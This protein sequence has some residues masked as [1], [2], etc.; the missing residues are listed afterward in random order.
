MR[1][2][3]A[4]AVMKPVIP[5]NMADAVKPKQDKTAD[6]Q[7]SKQQIATGWPHTSHGPCEIRGRPS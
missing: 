7:V 2:T 4:H 3:P 6:E 5:A 1:R